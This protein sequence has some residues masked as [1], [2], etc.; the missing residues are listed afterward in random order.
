MKKNSEKKVKLSPFVRMVKGPKNY[1]LY[2]LYRK[3]LYGIAPEGDVEELKQQ[4]VEAGLAIETA[5]VIPFKYEMNMDNYKDHVVLRELQIRV[6]GRCNSDCPGCGRICDCFRGGEDMADDVLDNVIEKFK[7]IPIT[8]VLITGGNPLLKFD[9]AKK[10]KES[11]PASQTV[12]FYKGKIE[13]PERQEIEAQGFQITDKPAFPQEINRDTLTAE[14][15][16]YFYSQ[17]YNLCWGHK[18]AVDIDG[19]I[20][21]C[22]WSEEVL[23]S[24]LNDNVKDMI[25]KGAFDKYWNLRK[26]SLE[27][28][29]QCEYRFGCPDCRV[30]A[31]KDSGRSTAKTSGCKYKPLLG[32]WD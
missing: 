21:A 28:C 25:I 22:L 7:N 11:I 9:F 29:H 32:T 17:K 10:I 27:S 14:P 1:A 13:Y 19:T 8:K 23:G 24:I 31:L 6:T 5:G 2:D 20:K 3:Q 26:E 16:T 4:L 12:L 18:V 15:F 30:L